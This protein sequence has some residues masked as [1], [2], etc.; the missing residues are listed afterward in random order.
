MGD[1]PGY[2]TFAD[3]GKP[4][5]RSAG[6][7]PTGTTPNTFLTK[8]RA[9]KVPA[10]FAPA[11]RTKTNLSL[12]TLS[13]ESNSTDR[14]TA[15]NLRN[16]LKALLCN[17]IPSRDAFLK[18]QQHTLDGLTQ[19]RKMCEQCPDIVIDQQ[20]LDI[21][22][23]SMRGKMMCQQGDPEHPGMPKPECAYTNA[24]YTD[25]RTGKKHWVEKGGPKK[26]KVAPPDVYP[27]MCPG[28]GRCTGCQY[29]TGG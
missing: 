3:E 15:A 11:M 18:L 13:E 2:Y 20:I 10:K 4:L 21:T 16:S 9:V 25:R 6:H 28:P 5:Q 29:C 7:F 14:A 22:E 19:V 17:S 26:W 8:S 12:A 1:N 27:N 23:P 24:G